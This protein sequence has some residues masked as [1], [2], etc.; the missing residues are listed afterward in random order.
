M[1]QTLFDGFKTYY[2]MKGAKIGKEAQEEALKGTRQEVL[3]QVY[4]AYYRL[5][6]SQGDLRGCRRIEKAEGRFSKH[7]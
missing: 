4:Q 1:K 6:R 2:D 7:G 5:A 3:S